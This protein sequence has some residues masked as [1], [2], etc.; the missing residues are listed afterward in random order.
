MKLTF[1]GIPYLIIESKIEELVTK[2]PKL[3]DLYKQ[4]ILQRFSPTQIEWL[5]KQQEPPEDIIGLLNAFNEAKQRLAEKDITKYTAYSLTQVLEEL[6]SS[7][8]SNKSQFKVKDTT[9]L[10]QFGPWL[11]VMPHTIE[12]SCY[13]GIGT[14]WCT[15]RTKSQNLFFNYTARPYQNIILYYVI[16]TTKNVKESNDAKL[17]IGFIDGVPIFKGDDGGVSVNAINTG[18]TQQSLH[19]ILQEQYKPI[20]NVMKLHSVSLAGKHPAKRQLEEAA[21]SIELFNKYTHK[22]HLEASLDFIELIGSYNPNE[23]VKSAIDELFRSRLLELITLHKQWIDG[24]YQDNKGKRLNLSYKEVTNIDIKG[25][26]L[27]RA[28]FE[29][30]IFHNVDL[31]GAIL[32]DADFGYSTL[33]D[34]NLTNTDLRTVNFSGSKIYNSKFSNVNLINAFMRLTIFEQVDFTEANLA[35]ADFEQSI[36]KRSIFCKSNIV[37]TSFKN[38]NL[39]QSNFDETYCAEANF[40][41]ADLKYTSFKNANLENINWRD[42]LLTGCSLQGASLKAANLTGIQISL[43]NLSGVNLEAAQMS[44]STI[45]ADMNDSNLKNANLENAQLSNTTFINANLKNANLERTDCSNVNFWKCN[46]EGA[47]LFGANLSGAQFENTNLT[48]TD[49]TNTIKN[50][51]Y[52]KNNKR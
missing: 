46:L 29:G 26:N 4:N 47:S 43:S 30:T 8:R 34:V 15:A 10:G 6:G 42:K 52:F 38:S 44:N 27:T 3:T 19:K 41:E 5:A 23:Q 48:D 13:W 12:S 39:Q 31:E 11:V 35:Y 1:L 18:I 20:L 9:V 36:L 21:Q 40:F 51:T 45:F 37:K 24:G 14:T 50:N 22:L 17:S 25:A 7:K 49:F 2:Y 28:F 33:K 16:D 32:D